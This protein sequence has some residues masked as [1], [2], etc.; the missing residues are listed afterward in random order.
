M[1][2]LGIQRTTA[3]LLILSPWIFI[4]TVFKDVV[5]VVAG[6]L[7]FVSTLDLRKRVVHSEHHQE[8]ESKP[9][10]PHQ[11]HPRSQIRSCKVLGQDL[12]KILSRLV[13]W[14]SGITDN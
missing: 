4:P 3:F 1:S 10:A 7:L 5:F 2:P 14:A 6:V 8:T 11:F 13:L 12:A 9:V